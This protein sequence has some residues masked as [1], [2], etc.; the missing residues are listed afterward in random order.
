MKTALKSDLNDA[1]NHAAKGTSGYQL[2]TANAD[3]TRVGRR[4]CS[5]GYAL[6]P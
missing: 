3:C 6:V 4:R 2:L 1:L 5:A